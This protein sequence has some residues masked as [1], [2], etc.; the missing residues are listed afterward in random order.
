M[1]PRFPES[2]THEKGVFNWEENAML[3]AT[4]GYSEVLLQAARVTLSAHYN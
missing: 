1:G 2:I 3:W 4:P